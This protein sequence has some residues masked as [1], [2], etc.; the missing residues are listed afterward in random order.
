MVERVAGKGCVRSSW[1]QLWT[2]SKGALGG[3]LWGWH[4]EL[5]LKR[6][7]FTQVDNNLL[8]ANRM[9]LNI[10]EGNDLDEKR[11]IL[12]KQCLC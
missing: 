2:A 5:L 12:N 8:I 9:L 1:V 4:L 6:K 7:R 10:N 3:T 11:R